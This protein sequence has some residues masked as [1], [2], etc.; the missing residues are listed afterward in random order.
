[1][2]K[3]IINMHILIAILL[4]VL[5]LFLKVFFLPCSFDLFCDLM[6]NLLLCLDYFFFSVGVYLYRFS[7][8][9]YHEVLIQQS[10]YKKDCSKSSIF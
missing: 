3:V 8:C 5:D 1:M 10:V 6:T 7:V 4:A 2:V 9:S